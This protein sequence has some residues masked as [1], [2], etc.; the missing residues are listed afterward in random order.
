M[1]TKLLRQKILDLA[2]KG[3]LVKQNP[4][5]EPA[6]VLLEKI[7]KEKQKLIKDGKIKKDKNESFIFRGSDNLHYE[8]F[9]N[10]FENPNN[11]QLTTLGE[12][13]YIING[14]SYNKNDV[15][16][17]GIRILRGG[18]I[19]NGQILLL[20][21]DV[22]LPAQY[23]DN[24]K[25]VKKND[26]IIVA[27]TGSME[28]IGKPG[29]AV[30]NMKNIQIGA[31]LRIVRPINQEIASYCKVIFQSN[32]Y[33]RHIRRLVKGTNIN[34][35]RSNYITDLIFPLPPLPEQK[36]I[37]KAIEQAFEKIT[38]IETNKK[39]LEELADKVK[40]KT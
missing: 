32:V 31:F 18:N 33:R 12:L 3:K 14:V 36:R 1:D 2:I 39:E 20:D 19:H 11:W 23:F 16:N 17:N 24:D 22:F 38:E 21:N 4:A 29:F 26:I 27:S 28:V 37:V 15:K 6:S 8:K 35:I 9:T 40:A 13:V 25:T 30:S 10:G 5:D 7:R 34:N